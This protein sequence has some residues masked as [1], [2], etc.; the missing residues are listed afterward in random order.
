MKN[1]KKRHQFS[2]DGALSDKLETLCRRPGTTK[3]EIVAKAV[4]A[5]LEMRGEREIDRRYG[6]RLDT[7]SRDLGRVRR[8][9][10]MILE[11]LAL[12]IRFSITL[13][14]HTP[15]P[16]EATQAIARE[17]FFR[18]VDQVGRQMASGKTSL[19]REGRGE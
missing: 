18:F 16:D 2:L 1:G 6:R 9:A 7:L 17:R 11:S 12:F 4:E 14:A 19:K 8:D 10:E 5:F 15:L 13:N 3:S